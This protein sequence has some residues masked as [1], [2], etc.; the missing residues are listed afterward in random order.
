[1]K[2]DIQT[3]GLGTAKRL[4]KVYLRDR[5]PMADN[6]VKRLA[7]SVE[8]ESKLAI[9]E[10]SAVDTGYLRS[11]IQ[12]SFKSGF[13]GFLI[14]VVKPNTNYDYAVH[15]GLGSN[16]RYGRRPYMD[17]GALRTVDKDSKEAKRL[18][19]EAISKMI[20]KAKVGE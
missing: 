20:A 5:V 19:D 15:E 9:T 11:T 1:M 6:I 16:R 12:A 4:H 2:V 17:V 8:R 13:A 7:Y 10:L 3:K 18:V 14:G